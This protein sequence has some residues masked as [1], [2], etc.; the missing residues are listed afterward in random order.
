VP[1]DLFKDVHTAGGI[2]HFWPPKISNAALSRIIPLM[3]DALIV[4]NLDQFY[5]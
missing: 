3:R 4:L 5:D 1:K 2:S